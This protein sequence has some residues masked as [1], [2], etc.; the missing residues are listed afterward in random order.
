MI[1]AGLSIATVIGLVGWTNAGLG[2]ASQIAINLTA[3]FGLASMIV[4]GPAMPTW[5]G[6]V[7]LWLAAIIPLLVAL[8]EIAQL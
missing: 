6:R 3:A 5:R 2:L 7:A 8:F 4:L 1:L